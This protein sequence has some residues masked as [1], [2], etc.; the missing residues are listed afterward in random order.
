MKYIPGDPDKGLVP[1]IEL[2]RR[3]LRTLL[4][5]LNDPFSARM[6]GSPAGPG[7]PYV[8][9]KAVEDSE[10]YSDRAPGEVHMPGG[11]PMTRLIEQLKDEQH[12]LCAYGT[13]EG[14][15][16]TCDCKYTRRMFLSEPFNLRGEITGCCEVR[17]AIQI[18]VQQQKQEAERDR[19][20]NQRPT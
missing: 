1:I 15:G 10:H 17:A 5:K 4:D 6:L 2:S 13:R 7:E 9:V 12:K 11:D 18:L 20:H 8:L 19:D 3:N 16:Q 14:D